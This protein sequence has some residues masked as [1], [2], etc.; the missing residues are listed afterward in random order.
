MATQYAFGKIVTD[1]LVLA[2]DAADK[3]SYPGSGTIWNDMSGNGNNGTLTNGPTFNSANGGS[4]VFDNVNDYVNLGTPSTLAG[5]QV[6]LTISLWAKIPT[7][8]SYDVL[9][10]AYG[11]TINSRLYS[12][13]RLDSG[14]FKYFTSTSNG[15]FQQYGTLVPIT[16]VWNFYAVTVSGTVSS[17]SLTIYLNTLSQSFSLSALSATPDLTVPIRIGA[18][19]S[20]TEPWNGNIAS[21]S[22]YNKALSAQ[23]ILQNYNAQKSRFNL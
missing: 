2:L 6:P 1:G 12:M 8:D 10:S 15:S 18:N 4:I 23:E 22:V 5:L 11:S 20:G 17:A 14:T 19:G 3:N 7:T 16:N 9:Y 13:L 21:C